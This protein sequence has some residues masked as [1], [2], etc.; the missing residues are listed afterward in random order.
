MKM[1]NVKAGLLAL[2]LFGIGGDSAAAGA[3]A[4]PFEIRQSFDIGVPAPPAPVRV[5]GT[6]QLTYELHL[7]NFARSPLDLVGVQILDDGSGQLIAEFRGAE[8]QSMIGRVG[9]P[10][11]GV[12]PAS[13]PS[14]ARA[15]IYVAVPLA[16]A[17]RPRALRHRIS[18]AA[19][20]AAGIVEGGAAVVDTRPLPILGPPLRGGPWVGVYDPSM[21]RGHRRV[22][23]AVGGRARIPGRFAIDWMRAPGSRDDGLGVDVLAVADAVVVATRDGVPEPARGAERPAVS[24][25]DAT[26]NYVALDLG[27]G[28]YAFYEH[29]MPGLSVRPG[30]RVRE[31]QVIAKLGSTG[32]ASQPHLHFHV[33]DA[34]FPLAEGLP[35]LLKGFRTLGAYRSIEEFGQGGPWRASAAPTSA[36]QFP[37]PN[38]VVAFPD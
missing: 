27:G 30:D 37:A 29:L 20:S 17:T 34:D 5:G 33:A 32:Q 10:V 35:Y 25:A 9:A 2:T 13:I 14:G 6:T 28:R 7:T 21:E 19:A 1:W 26:G 31:G 22:V 15:I 24:L 3:A 8:L 38:L 18:Y 11:E 12:R 36:P 4:P 23:Y 16:S